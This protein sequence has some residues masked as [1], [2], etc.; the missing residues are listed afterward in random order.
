MKAFAR[1][2]SI[3][4]AFPL[5]MGAHCGSNAGAGTSADVKKQGWTDLQTKAWYTASQGSRLVPQAWLHA[6]EQPGSS[7]PFLDPA[8]IAKFRY[9]PGPNMT[10]L[11]PPTGACAYDQS[12]PLG[13]TVDCR[14]DADWHQTK[15]RWRQNQTDKEP[16]V[17]M[18]CSACHT[19]EVTYNGKSFRFE[20]GPTL[21]DFQ[22][23]IEALNSALT[24][25]STDQAKFGR[26]AGTVLG[27][28]ASDQDRAM[29]A[30]ALKNLVVWN[31]KLAALNDV[32][33][34]PGNKQIRYGY[35]RL[36]AIGHIYN[37]V[38]L[39]ALREDSSDVTTQIANPSDAPVS[40]PFLWNVTQ[41][42]KVEWN[43]IAPNKPV[44]PGAS[45]EF[46]YGAL[47]R[48]TG[49]VIGV[50]ADLT[51]TPSPGFG[52]YKSSVD[53]GI[54]ND[55]ERQLQTLEPPKWPAEFGAIDQ[56]LAGLGKKLFGRKTGDNP[57]G[58]GCVACHA[59][60]T[61]HFDK[62]DKY[63]TNLTPVNDV[64]T[65]M[66]MACNAVF[67]TAKAGAFAGTPAD[68]IVE[69][70][71]LGHDTGTA[72]GKVE[73]NLNLVHN[74]VVGALLGQ[75]L[76]LV[77]SAVGDIFGIT[78][79]LPQPRLPGQLATDAKLS[80]RNACNGALNHKVAG[81]S[82]ALVYKGRPLQGIWAT[83]PYLHN[84]SVTTLYELL[85]PAAQRKS[86]FSTGTR[87]YDPK[88]VGLVTDPAAAGNDFPFDTSIEGNFNAGHDY[89]NA[90]I[91]EP[92]RRALVEYMKTL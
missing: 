79:G 53:V 1:T 77:G 63:Q 46:D 16:W 78:Q 13:F 59:M 56:N 71:P 67:D 60:P 92:E 85:L 33:T 32:P 54:L 74:A 11:T 7:T 81:V 55:M 14:S 15:L 8:F 62:D 37:K 65:D 48:N 73:S 66:W 45:N 5:L 40:Y 88:D 35:G 58:Q 90:D 25:T 69:G 75:K 9:L 86:T 52:G 51:I 26:F 80:R 50:F 87:A 31:S 10:G 4:A 70:S 82:E 30:T 41:L 44:G 76:K 12:L 22:S 49:E 83:P 17:G 57:R 18:N 28:G 20:G 27:A 21:A 19:S 43:G 2:L 36:D 47:G 6:L 23:F 38:A 68:I 61:E 84:G 72:D 89:N 64:K 24:N 29:L 39:T 91:T 42:D 34:L 3:I